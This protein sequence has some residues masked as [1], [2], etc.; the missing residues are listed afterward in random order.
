MTAVADKRMRPVLDFQPGDQVLISIKHFQL[1]S[2]LCQ[3][4]APRKMGPFTIIRATP[5]DLVYEVD[6]PDNVRIH[7]T[8]HI[9]ALKP[10][11]ASGSYQPP[12]AHIWMLM[13]SWRILLML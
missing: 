11:N 12:P 3:K 6:L 5:S 7:P 4:L 8:V 9:S 1:C 2:D 13:A 10:Y